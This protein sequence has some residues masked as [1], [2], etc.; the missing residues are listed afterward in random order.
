MTPTDKIDLEVFKI[1]HRAIAQSDQIDIM[2]A[3]LT[4]LLV[5]AMGIKG[6]CLFAR[7]VESAELEVLGSFGLSIAYINKGPVMFDDR[8]RDQF[9]QRPLVISDVSRSELLQYPE[10]AQREG[11]AAIVSLPIDFYGKTIGILRLYHHQVWEVSSK[12]QDY[13]KL[14]ADNIGLA[15]MYIRLLTVV[16]SIKATVGDVHSVWLY[17]AE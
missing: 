15:M 6:A 12:D 8:I 11:I 9:K 5:A 2:A 10:D 3:H 4:Q 13:L 14:L 7:N 1:V 17:P 16:R